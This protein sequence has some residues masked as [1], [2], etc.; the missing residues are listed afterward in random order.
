VK[1]KRNIER[2]VTNSAL[3][4]GRE[5]LFNAFL[6]RVDISRK[7]KLKIEIKIALVTDKYKF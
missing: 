2:K 4:K 3:A 1:V 5:R 7:E 6:K